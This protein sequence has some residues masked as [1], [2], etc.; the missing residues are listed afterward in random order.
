MQR[1]PT[2]TADTSVPVTQPSLATEEFAL[3]SLTEYAILIRQAR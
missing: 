1:V 3:V 2:L